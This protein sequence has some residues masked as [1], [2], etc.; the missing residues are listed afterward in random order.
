MSASPASSSATGLSAR[1]Q[2]IL[3]APVLP[4]LLTLALPN[5]G[6]AAARIPFLTADALF[7][8]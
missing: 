7:V 3:E 6:E 4:L 5:I 8:S 1:T 2:R